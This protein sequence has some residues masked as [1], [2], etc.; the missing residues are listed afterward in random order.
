MCGIAGIAQKCFD[1]PAPLDDVIAM[2]DAIRHRGPDA[3]DYFCAGPLALGHR[4]LSILDLSEAGTQPMHSHDDRYVLVFNGEIY[5][6]IELR[7]ELEQQGTRFRTRTDTEVILEAYRAWGM[8]CIQRFNGMWAFALFDRAEQ[9]LFLS[10][11]R[12]GIKPFYYLD[13]P[14][15]F[16]F[17]SEIKAILTVRPAQRVPHWATL[18]RF[19]PTGLFADGAE[20]F[21]ANIRS[22]LPGHNAVYDLERGDLRIWRFW[23]IEPERFAE[24]W[25]GRDPVEALRELLH[26]SVRL[27]M[28]SDVPV[29]TCLSGGVDSSALVCLMSQCDP[30][31][32]HTF[33]GIYADRDCNEK[34][35]VDVVNGHVQTI[36]CAVLPEPAGDLLE[37][38]RTITWHQDNPTGG[39][40]LYTQYHVMRRASRDVK[41]ILDGQG[42]D[43]LFAGYL[44]YFRAH[45]Q[46]KMRTGLRGKF[47]SLNLLAGI[48][49]HW[50]R[51]GVPNLLDGRLGGIAN[52]VL[53]RFARTESFAAA[54]V[55][56]PDLA[57]RAG[58]ALLSRNQ[59]PAPRGALN[60]VLQD[61]LVN[62]SLPALLHYEDRNS[63]AFSLEAR[64]PFLDYRIVEFA[65]SL[66]PKYKIS[67]T[68]TKWVLRKAVEKIVPTKVAWRR[69]KMGYPTPMARWFRKESERD[70]IADLLFSSTCRQRGILESAKLRQA[71]ELHQHGK[72][73]SWL[74]YRA[75]TL[76]LWFRHFIDALRPC[77]AQGPDRSAAIS[78]GRAA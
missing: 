4:R 3:A 29:G 69:S 78:V 42:S 5:N 33:S 44:W 16:L 76:E 35:Y 62:S 61:Q 14:D 46:D 54:N 53:R 17:A 70:A 43:E 23:S 19:I 75:V 71:W 27:H 67:S 11:D 59:M 49:W 56:H 2:C 51:A 15:S 66:D 64:V 32:V 60:Q 24:Q 39:P 47:E 58:G 55:V 12:F 26:S 34:E 68:W 37:D 22:L 65:L 45:L 10:R 28:R 40:G 20:T 77:A 7:D 57:H 1:R 50:G 38:L 36:P 74:L 63:M 41:V 9:K 48:W 13:E 31:A 18:A 73:Y 52:K 21:F 8:D 25:A 72:D 6:Y 30:Q